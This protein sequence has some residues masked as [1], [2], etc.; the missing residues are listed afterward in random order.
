VGGVLS[1]I[2]ALATAGYQSLRAAR[3]NPVDAL[4]YE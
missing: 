3:A 1:A 2:L 4:R